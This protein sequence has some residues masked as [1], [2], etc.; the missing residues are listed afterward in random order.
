MTT[1]G[2]REFK[3]PNLLSKLKKLAPLPLP[4]HEAQFKMAPV[5]RKDKPIP[6]SHSD[7]PKDSAVILFLESGS[8]GQTYIYFILRKKY[9][10]VHSGQIGFPGGKLETGDPDLM[11]AGMR[12]AY[13][14][15]GIN[16]DCY[17][18][19]QSLTSLYVPASHFL[20]HPFLAIIERPF[21]PKIEHREVEEL[22]RV[23]L[24]LFF[25]NENIKQT[26]MTF[27]NH[28]Q[29]DVP[30]YDLFGKVLWGATAMITSELVE[31]IRQL[32]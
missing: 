22:I 3:L 17:S 24:S 26:R 16:P 2:S 30:Y 6:Y 10:G 18:I 23:P 15:I 4:G 21:E 25:L 13:E 7:D 32:R 9:K 28:Y 19:I 20:I 14:E 5:G 12:E 1:A 8:A 29:T 31:M 27:S 11:H